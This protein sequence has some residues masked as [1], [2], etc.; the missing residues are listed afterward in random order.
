MEAEA[1]ILTIIT[2]SFAL[3]SYSNVGPNSVKLQ[4]NT[5]IVLGIPYIFVI[6]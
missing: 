2:D 4:S 6:Q 1:I 5:D 3:L